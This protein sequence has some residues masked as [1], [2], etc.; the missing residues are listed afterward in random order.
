MNWLYLLS[1]GIALYSVETADVNQ[2]LHITALT[3][4]CLCLIP[5][6][7]DALRATAKSADLTRLLRKTANA[8]AHD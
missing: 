5:T 6:T 3:A 7:L 1:G 2:P 8:K 4:L